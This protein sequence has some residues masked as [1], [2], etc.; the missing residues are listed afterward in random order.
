MSVNV[1][2][3]MSFIINSFYFIRGMTERKP[4]NNEQQ[5]TI[6]EN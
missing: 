3:N 6:Y 4:M 2:K 5:Q 1:C